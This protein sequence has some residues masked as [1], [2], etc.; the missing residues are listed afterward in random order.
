MNNLEIKKFKDILKRKPESHKYDY[1]HVLAVVGSRLM[2]GA[3]VLCT[4]AVLRAGAGLVSLGV[5]DK[6]LNIICSMAAPETLFYVY[7]GAK[8]I[9]DHMEKSKVSAL[10]IGC[11]LEK[12]K[13]N[14]KMITELILNSDKPIVLDASGLTSFCGDYSIF[15]RAKAPLIITPHEGEF[16]ALIDK[17]IIDIKT[18]AEELA[19]RF[20][21][22]N[23]VI[24][25]LKRHDTIVASPSDFYIN[26]TGTAAMASA[27]S[28]DVLTGVIAGLIARKNLPQS[29]YFFMVKF[30]VWLCGLSGE[31]AAKQKG[32]G[33]IASDLIE[34][35]PSAVQLAFSAPDF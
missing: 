5:R 24:L 9:L 22:A 4:R 28:G 12:N 29:E 23:N 6:F 14:K 31:I 34:T 19:V 33:L 15:R 8:D 16:A 3:G 35:L 27:G 17:P 25:V 1:G 32:D 11:G 30:A 21:K 26:D 10:A 2:P 20:C 7:K 18:D 13:A